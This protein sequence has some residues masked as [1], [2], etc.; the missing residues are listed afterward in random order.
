MIW[1]FSWQHDKV[2]VAFFFLLKS[3]NSARKDNIFYI[4]QDKKH[5]FLTLFQDYSLRNDFTGFIVA[6]RRLRKVTTAIVT[7]KTANNAIANTQ[8]CSGT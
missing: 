6:A 2:E 5:I 8:T 1:M 4:I 3:C 7:A